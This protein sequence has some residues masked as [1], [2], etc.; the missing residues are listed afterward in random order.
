MVDAIDQ[1][2]IIEAANNFADLA[3]TFRDALVA[4]EFS[5]PPAEQTALMMAA[6]MVTSP[7]K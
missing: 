3:A 2:G 1:L 6:N 4:R 5:V 7:R